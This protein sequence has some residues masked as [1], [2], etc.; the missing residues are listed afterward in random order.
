M[1]RGHG[2]GDGRRDRGITE[3]CRCRRAGNRMDSELR[4][5]LAALDETVTAGFARDD[6]IRYGI[7]LHGTLSSEHGQRDPRRVYGAQRD[8]DGA[9]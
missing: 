5:A 3:S 9:Q 8:G 6:P 7:T 4:T 1:F 2:Y